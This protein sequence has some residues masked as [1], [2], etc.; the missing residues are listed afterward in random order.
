MAPAPSSRRAAAGGRS[1]WPTCTPA[2]PDS[3]R[4][5]GAVVDDDRRADTA[6]RMRDDR[7]AEVEERAGRRAAWRGA[8][9]SVAPPSR[10]RAREIER[11]P[12]GAR[13][14][15]DVEDRVQSGNRSVDDRLR[16][17]R[18]RPG[19]S[20]LLGMN[21]SMNA[22]LSR[23]AWKSGSLRIFRCSGTVVLMP[24]MTVISSVRRMRAIA[25]CRSRPCTMILAII[26]S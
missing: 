12:A 11:R 3:T 23:P 17:L 6:R 7:V 1:S 5:V 18:Q 19:G 13:R 9:C 26:E 14:R 15:V 4:E 2:A 16:A 25:S 22:V 8:E 21:R 10:K 20:W 24:S